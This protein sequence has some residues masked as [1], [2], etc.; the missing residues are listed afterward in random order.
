MIVYE[1]DNLGQ[2]NPTLLEH[3][4]G[5]QE[6]RCEHTDHIR[7]AS[8]F[9]IRSS[10]EPFFPDFRRGVIGGTCRQVGWVKDD[11]VE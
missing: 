10:A 3:A 2:H 5:F 6:K 1:I 11:D 7:A 8:T 9:A 4:A